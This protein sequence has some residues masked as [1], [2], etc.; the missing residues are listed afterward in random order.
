MLHPIAGWKIVDNCKQYGQHNI[1]QAC[2]SKLC[3][4]TRDLSTYPFSGGFGCLFGRR[5]GC[6]FV[7][8]VDRGVRIYFYA[9]NLGLILFKLKRKVWILIS[10][11][12]EKY[13][14]T[15]TRCWIR[16]AV[17]LTLDDFQANL[18]ISSGVTRG[19]NGGPQRH[20]L[21]GGILTL[22]VILFWTMGRGG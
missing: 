13:E 6:L 17:T 3:V 7:T 5:V 11:T 22:V 1:V 4:F 2:C 8:V 15:V 12:R 14:Y 20:N 16:I 19:D 21:G 9:N 18:L 10:S